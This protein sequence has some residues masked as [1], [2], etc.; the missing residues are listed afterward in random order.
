MAD[1]QPLWILDEPLAALDAA[2]VEQVRSLANGHLARGGM[3]VLTTHQDAHVE[4]T[5]VIDIRLDRQ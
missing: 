4:A 1:S 2:A 5:S 3:V